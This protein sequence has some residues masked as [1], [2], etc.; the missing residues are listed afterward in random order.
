V[1]QATALGVAD[2]LAKPFDVV[3]CLASIAAHVRQPTA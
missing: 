2:Y 3:A 1:E